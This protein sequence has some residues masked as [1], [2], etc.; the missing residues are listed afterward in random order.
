MNPN[1][2]TVIEL[3]SLVSDTG[4]VREMPPEQ[5]ARY[6]MTGFVLL[7]F[8]FIFTCLWFSYCFNLRSGR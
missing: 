7:A 3:S 6:T 1:K 2:S 4:E 8:S 5:Q